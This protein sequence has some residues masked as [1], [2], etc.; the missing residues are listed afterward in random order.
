[1]SELRIGAIGACLCGLLSGVLAI[2]FD[3]GKPYFLEVN[4]ESS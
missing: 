2:I 3:A 1:M 4:G